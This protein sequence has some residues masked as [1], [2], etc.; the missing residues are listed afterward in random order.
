MNVI[1]ALADHL[2][3]HIPTYSWCTHTRQTP[4]STHHLIEGSP[5][6]HFTRTSITIVQQDNLLV[7]MLS[8]TGE[9]APHIIDLTDPEFLTKTLQIVQNWATL[10]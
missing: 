1:P 3:Q 10:A 9:N 8:S 4:K 7:L 5:L 2:R 6:T